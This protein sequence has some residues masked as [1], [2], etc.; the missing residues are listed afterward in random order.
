MANDTK[1]SPGP[2]SKLK[3]GLAI[4]DCNGDEICG[5]PT[6]QRPENQELRAANMAL[7]EAA[8]ELLKLLKEIEYHADEGEP[9]PP[10]LSI[11]VSELIDKIEGNQ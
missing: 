3:Y 10:G 7:V 6:F 1:H 2:W 8:P 9:I 11:E 5:F 4:Y